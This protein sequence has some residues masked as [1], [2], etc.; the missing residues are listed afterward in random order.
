MSVAPVATWIRVAD[1]NPIIGYA[2]S[3]TTS[4]RSNVAASNPL[5]TPIH[6]PF[7]DSTHQAALILLAEFPGI[8]STANSQPSLLAAPGVAA[9]TC[10]RY[11]YRTATLNPWPAQNA[12]RVNPLDSYSSTSRFP[13]SRLIRPIHRRRCTSPTAKS[14]MPAWTNGQ[15]QHMNVSVGSSPLAREPFGG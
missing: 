8:P 13:A 14:L 15:I 10:R 9:A 4:K 3:S 5:P 6:S 7:A 1:P 12:S 2:Y 11:R